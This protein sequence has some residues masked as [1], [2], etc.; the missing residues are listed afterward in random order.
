MSQKKAT[1]KAVFE[2]CQQLSASIEYA[3]SWNR[4][5][6]RLLV[7]GGS[8]AVIDPLIKAW[9]KL[10]PVRE[11]APTIP[12]ELLIQVATLLEQQVTGY[13][14]EVQQADERRELLFNQAGEEL[15]ENLHGLESRL[16]AELD[17]AHQAN[18]D[19]ESECSRLEGELTQSQQ[20]K[21]SLELRL[22]LLEKELNQAGIR[23]AAEKERTDK[24]IKQNQEDTEA[25]RMLMAEQNTQ[26][27]ANN[28]LD[29]QQQ[30]ASQKKQL[31][32]AA[33]LAENRLMRLLDQSRSEIKEAQQSF[34][35]KLADLN[36]QQ[37]EDKQLINKQKLE[38]NVNE[39]ELRQVQ[40]VAAQQIA[41]L[42]AQVSQANHECGLLR[43]QL[44]QQQS[45]NTQGDR[46]DLQAIKDSILSLQGQLNG[47][48]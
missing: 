8:F 28:K 20:E 18:H 10:Q 33:E 3:G 22:E 38:I 31:L 24:I 46:A 32:D 1:P 39:S 2:A 11:V 12:S 6:V 26:A 16:T 25:L 7:G 23:L 42:E 36:L 41:D 37:Q 13:I 14:N 34:E 45:E 29:Y 27:L 15:A 48:N 9:R 19:L 5:D 17:S 47:R 35:Y 21:H 43:D 40:Q 4:D 44:L 30:L